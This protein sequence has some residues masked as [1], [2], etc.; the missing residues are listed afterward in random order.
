MATEELWKLR[1]TDEAPR[2]GS[3]YRMVKVKVGRK[4]V[5]LSAYRAGVLGANL[6]PRKQRISRAIWSALTASPSAQRLD[7]VC[8]G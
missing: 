2:I 4:W 8:E 1:L 3:G 5:H 6:K 7:E